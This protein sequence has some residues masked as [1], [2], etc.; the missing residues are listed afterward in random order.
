MDLT[1]ISVASGHFLHVLQS[2]LTNYVSYS[3]E[4]FEI[5][6]SIQKTGKLLFLFMELQGSLQKEIAR[7]GHGDSEI[8]SYALNRRSTVSAIR[9]VN[10]GL[11]ADIARQKEEFTIYLGLLHKNMWRK[12]SHF[13]HQ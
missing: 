8:P 7:F 2:T 13:V 1:Y 12:I 11:T 6:P 4:T 5:T 9:T 3:R 10:E